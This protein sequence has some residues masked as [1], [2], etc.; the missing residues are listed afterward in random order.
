MAGL[1]DGAAIQS[2]IDKFETIQSNP[3]AYRGVETG[4]TLLDKMTNGLQKSDLIVLAARPGM[5]KT[6]FSMNIVAHAC[7]NKGKVAA[8]FSLEMPRDR[9]SVV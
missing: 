5:G 2:V 6:S 9:K 8:V 4:F 3:N 7:L 1:E